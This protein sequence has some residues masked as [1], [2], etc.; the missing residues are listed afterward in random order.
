MAEA[1]TYRCIN[2]DEADRLLK[3]GGI[4]ILDVRDPKSFAA[5][6]MDGARHITFS[7]LGEI[8]NATARSRPVLFCCY[9][10][11]AS[12]EYAN[13]LCD[14]GFRNVYS[15]DGGYEAW[16]SFKAADAAE[17]GPDGALRLWLQAQGFPAD[18]VNAA[19]PNGMT[20]LMRACRDG[21]EERVAALIAA[22]ARLEARNAD[23]NTALWLACV[24][25]ST[26]VIETL[27]QAGADLDNINDNGATALMYSASAGKADVVAC[28]L[29]HGADLRPETPEGF[30]ALDL[31][32]T[33]DCLQL[34]RA[35][36]KAKAPA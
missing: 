14:F 18:D 9:H 1:T 22:G 29:R 15:L 35:A 34:L 8:I 3:E 21:Q 13:V 30:S 23:G 24:S 28:L 2:V 25:G 5:G 10:G 4:V 26:V 36:S 19:G 33:L 16:A 17:G 31:A 32:S 6:H 12:Q 20:P 11:F 7:D 27:V